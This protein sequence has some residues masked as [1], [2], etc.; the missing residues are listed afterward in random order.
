MKGLNTCG[1]PLPM[2]HKPNNTAKYCSG[3]SSTSDQAY[4]RWK[5]WPLSGTEWGR[6]VSQESPRGHCRNETPFTGLYCT[7]YYFGSP[8]L[9]ISWPK[10]CNEPGIFAVK[11][12]ALTLEMAKGRPTDSITRPTSLNGINILTMEELNTCGTP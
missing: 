5:C 7:K 11:Y 8:T 1:T 2:S 12:V 4:Q 10:N 3:P 9:T 6:Q